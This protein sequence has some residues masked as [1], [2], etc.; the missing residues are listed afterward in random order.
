MNAV[1]LLILLT[2]IIFNCC[3]SLELCLII[4]SDPNNMYKSNSAFAE[5][6]PLSP[7]VLPV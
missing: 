1:F 6:Q 2:N 3:I 5:I 4:T 7:P